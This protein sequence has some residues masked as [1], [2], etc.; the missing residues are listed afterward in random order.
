MKMNRKLA[1]EKL[2][3]RRL[4]AVDTLAVNDDVV[5]TPETIQSVDSSVSPMLTVGDANSDGT[6]DQLDLIQVLSANKY[7]SGQHADW[8]EGDWNGDH[9]FDQLDLVHALQAGN[10]G[11]GPFDAA[12]GKQVPIK[13]SGGGIVG[14]TLFG[15]AS[16]MG[17]YT[18]SSQTSN[19]I[20]SVDSDGNLVYQFDQSGDIVGAN[21]DSFHFVGACGGPFLDPALTGPISCDYIIDGGTGRFDGA[22]GTLDLTGV[23]NGE[24]GTF[25]VEWSGS[26][27]TVGSLK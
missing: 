25:V 6:F 10:Y 23:I 27:S 2:E 4:L 11:H 15:N 22:T 7:M 24:E 16:H 21:G 18:G 1:T 9:V 20:V 5:E 19:F 3:C 12:A 8:A 13:A 26:I 17:K 14:G